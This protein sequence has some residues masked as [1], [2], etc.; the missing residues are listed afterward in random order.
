MGAQ[1]LMMN[2]NSQASENVLREALFIVFAQKRLIIDTV[3]LVFVIVLAVAFLSPEKFSAHTTL[4][5]KGKRIERNPEAVVQ[6]Q[7]RKLP[8]SR[9]DL[10]SEMRILTSLELIKR[11][12]LAVDEKYQLFNLNSLDEGTALVVQSEGES[13]W[14]PQD[15][16]LTKSIRELTSALKVTVETTSNILEVELSWN[17]PAEAQQILDVLIEHYF[18]YRNTVYKPE[19]V[20]NFYDQTVNAYQK[21]IVQEQQKLK[22]IIDKIKASSTHQEIESNL[23]L[24][25]EYQQQ[26][27]ALELSRLKQQAQLNDLEAQLNNSSVDV[28][29]TKKS[30]QLF[31][32]L[33]NTAI[34]ELATSVRVNFD[35]YSNVLQYFLPKSEKAIIAKKNLDSSYALLLQEVK[36]IRQHLRGELKSVESSINFLHKKLLELDTRNTLLGTLQIELDQV[37]RDKA[38]LEQS[39]ANYFKLREEADMFDRTQTANL[40]T[41]IIILT[42]PWADENA[43]FPNKRLMIPFG[44]IIAILAALTVGFIKEYFDDTIK[45]SDDS[46]KYLGVPAI[47]SLKDATKEKP[48]SISYKLLQGLLKLFNFNK[49]RSV[50]NSDKNLNSNG[51][52]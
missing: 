33:D 4:L 31:T 50:S 34:R 19:K 8:I 48:Q 28:I 7:E 51:K 21:S 18:S 16:K 12:V 38:L 14:L 42:R 41:Q 47:V 2:S 23:A 35:Q 20:R 29:K 40:N 27:G 15:S 26:L 10:N 44:L 11:T 49:N 36:S 37:E 1:S 32:H 3:V 46:L 45:R 24:K 43:T 25:K 13:R 5:V 9:E 52:G 30:I 17:S 22:V 39:F 6:I